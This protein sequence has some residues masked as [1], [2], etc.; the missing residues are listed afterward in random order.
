M[1]SFPNARRCCERRR[2]FRE[3]KPT[4]SALGSR[5]GLGSKRRRSS[6]LPPSARSSLEPG[7]GF[8][9]RQEILTLPP[10]P[11]SK[12][13]TAIDI[14]WYFLYFWLTIQN[15]ADRQV[16]NL[17]CLLAVLISFPLASNA[18]GAKT[19]AFSDDLQIKMMTVKMMVWHHTISWHLSSISLLLA[20]CV[21]L[22]YVVV[23]S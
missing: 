22:L 14:C 17:G 12:H 18:S 1:C 8:F 3:S 7:T 23:L 9:L 20:A 5:K 10:P 19:E 13:P 21:A 16:R 15:T 6:P 11:P 2:C 4:P